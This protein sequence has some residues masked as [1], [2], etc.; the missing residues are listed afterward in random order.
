[1]ETNPAWPVGG[2]DSDAMHDFRRD[3]RDTAESLNTLNNS[4][5]STRAGTHN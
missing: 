5:D 1:M 3:A 4:L 2:G